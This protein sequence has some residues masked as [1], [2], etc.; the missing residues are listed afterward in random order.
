MSNL[1]PLL[2]LGLQ[3]AQ[4]ESGLSAEI[5]GLHAVDASV[6]WAAARDGW[7]AR[8]TDGG[9][10]WTAD[11]VPGA[12]GLFFVDVHAVSAGTA[13]LLGQHF[14][15]GLARIYRTDDGGASW[16]LQFESTH[17]DIFL[18]GLAFWTPEHGI[19]FGDPLDG[20]FVILRTWD[21][22]V[23]WRRVP[24][25]SLPPPLEGEAG[26][27]ASG[28]AITTWGDRH[29]W[30]G[31]GGGPVARVLYTTDAG[32]SWAAAETPLPAGR[33]AGLFGIAFRDAR[34]GVAVG[35]DYTRPE[36]PD[37]NVI[38]TADGG[39]TWRL[40]G[41]AAPAGVRWGLARG[42]EGP[43][44]AVGPS[45]VGTSAD[46]SRWTALDAPGYNTVTAVRGLAW[47]AGTDGRIAR[48]ALP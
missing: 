30:I 27:A 2:L 44:V 34:H 38:V 47:L 35:G 5:R 42:P 40:A 10:H 19:A 13:Y 23:T 1:L 15:G 28:T 25:D 22:G 37:T 21:G 31:T 17:P 3:V 43:W 45:G 12:S 41:V 29:A 20:S 9:A 26:F 8:T 33:T 48:V 36:A 11:T 14:E 7:F 39:R 4:Q 46:G 6:V 32:R 16:Q 18:D 24:A